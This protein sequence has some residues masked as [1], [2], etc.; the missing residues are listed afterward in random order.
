HSCAVLLLDAEQSKRARNIG[1]QFLLREQAGVFE[2]LQVGQIA[3]RVEPELQQELFG[4]DISVW[5]ARLRRAGAGGDQ[6]KAPEVADQ[7]ARYLPPE[8]GGE[9][10]AG[11]RLEV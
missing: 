9:V 10:S 2:L 8:E 5:R 7:V 11:D 1:Q 6:A 3:Q 4:G